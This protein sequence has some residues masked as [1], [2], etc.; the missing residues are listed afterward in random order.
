MRL[1]QTMSLYSGSVVNRE[2]QQRDNAA[3]VG[4]P[5]VLVDGPQGYGHEIS[6]HDSYDDAYKAMMAR[7]NSSIKRRPIL[8][9]LQENRDKHIAWSQLQNPDIDAESGVVHEVDLDLGATS[10]A[11]VS[12]GTSLRP[13][14][15]DID[16]PKVRDLVRRRQVRTNPDVD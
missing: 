14:N 5:F 2:P 13:R 7:P 1:D 11:P 10:A 15:D 16:T 8:N 6:E 4:K 9:Q 12:P 3:F